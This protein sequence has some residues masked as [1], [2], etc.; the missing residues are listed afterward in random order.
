MNPDTLIFHI[1]GAQCRLDIT[2]GSVVY[3]GSDVRADVCLQSP[4][5]APAHCAIEVLANAH[6][7]VATLDGSA[8]LKL[9]GEV[10]HDSTVKAPFTLTIDDQELEVQLESLEKKKGDTIGAPLAAN[11]GAFIA[12]AGLLHA[13]HSSGSISRRSESS[14]LSKLFENISLSRN[15]KIALAATITLGCLYG[16]DKLWPGDDDQVIATQGEMPDLNDLKRKFTL[17][18]FSYT[19]NSAERVSIDDNDDFDRYYAD[20]KGPWTEAEATNPNT[21]SIYAVRL[22]VTNLDEEKDQPFGTEFAL[23]NLNQEL[24]ESDAGASQTLVHKFNM[25]PMPTRLGPGAKHE[26]L[27]AFEVPGLFN[28]AG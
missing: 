18:S 21:T 14:L 23:T 22:E 4:G 24:F 20:S 19:V 9:N 5:I 13:G 12:H 26:C 15:T 6:F 3:V 11:S 10:T 8:T 16:A 7:R 28:L 17:G 1:A 25:E 27:V 2:E